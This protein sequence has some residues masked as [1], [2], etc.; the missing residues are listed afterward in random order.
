MKT[1]SYELDVN[2]FVQPTALLKMRGENEGTY[3]GNP[4]AELREAM[5]EGVPF[6]AHTLKG[7]RPIEMIVNPAHVATITD[8]TA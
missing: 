7:L 3:L 5:G 2:Q 6:V 8:L 4:M 1:L